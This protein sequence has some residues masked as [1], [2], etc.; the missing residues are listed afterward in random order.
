MVVIHPKKSHH[1]QTETDKANEVSKLM[2]SYL[3]Q[4]TGKREFLDL[5]DVCRK[6]LPLLE[7]ALPG[8]VAMKINLPSPGPAIKANADQIQ[9]IL[10]NLATNAWEASGNDDGSIYLTVKK[11]SSAK[12]PTSHRFPVDWLPENTLHA[13]LEIQDSGCG[14]DNKSIEEIFSPFYSTKFTGRGLGLSV[15]LGL[16]KAHGGVVPV[17]SWENKGSVFRAFFPMSLEEL[18]QQPETSANAHEIQCSGNVLMIDDDKMV[19]EFTRSQTK[20]HGF[21]RG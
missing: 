17:E 7:I 21:T 1:C 6:M 2:L 12:I 8:N 4:V 10:V 9:Q 16:V 15:V 13:C 18:A 20:R 3:G 11:V 14:I 5:S 19:L